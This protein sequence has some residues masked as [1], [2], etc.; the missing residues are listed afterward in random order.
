MVCF[1]PL[2]L[3]VLH[4]A[5]DVW[6]LNCNAQAH[7]SGLE[8]DAKSRFKC[9]R[10]T[11]KNHSFVPQNQHKL[12]HVSITFLKGPASHFI[13]SQHTLTLLWNNNTHIWQHQLPSPIFSFQAQ[14]V[15]TPSNPAALLSHFPTLLHIVPF[16]M[17][18]DNM[19]GTLAPSEHE[20]VSSPLSALIANARTLFRSHAA[21]RESSAENCETKQTEEASNSPQRCWR[22]RDVSSWEGVRLFSLWTS[23]GWCSTAAQVSTASRGRQS[24]R[25]RKRQA[26]GRLKGTH[27]I[28]YPT[29]AE[30]NTG[31]QVTHTPA[32][33]LRGNGH[34][35][36]ASPQ[37]K[38]N[39]ETTFT[40]APRWRWV[41]KSPVRKI[42]VYLFLAQTPAIAWLS[43]WA[44]FGFFYTRKSPLS[45]P[46]PLH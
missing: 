29:S 36:S 24:L 45:K 16:H 4:K 5:Q 20:G 30:A 15:N 3:C 23:P 33:C 44:L 32:Q 7:T 37:H 31:P 41:R 19:W 2:F 43:L 46:P 6:N 22:A 35:W 25:S 10:N 17:K 27:S 38:H 13:Q 28:F 12:W 39:H 34:E 8:S 40:A 42:S 14:R 21:T 18:R 1:F 11:V 26:V 9:V